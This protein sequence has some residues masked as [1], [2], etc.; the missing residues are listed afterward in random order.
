MQGLAVGAGYALDVALRLGVRRNP[1]ESTHSAL[2]GI[3]A[4]ERQS[5][6]TLESNEQPAQIGHPAPEILNR[7]RYIVDAETRRSGRH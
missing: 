2:A 5:Q 1:I 3:V 6:I 4:C 7:I